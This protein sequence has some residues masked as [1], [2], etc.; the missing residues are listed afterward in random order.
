MALA[1]ETLE[2][3]FDMTHDSVSTDKTISQKL[4]NLITHEASHKLSTP[5][6]TSVLIF[7]IA[8]GAAATLLA[9]IFFVLIGKGWGKLFGRK[10]QGVDFR[11][12]LQ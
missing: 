11:W 3:S 5:Q 6:V 2:S 12:L 4:N 10:K 8:L 9:R 1:K 7:G